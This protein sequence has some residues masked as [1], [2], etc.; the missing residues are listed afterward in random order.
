MSKPRVNRPRVNRIADS[1]LVTE[2]YLPWI[3]GIN[4]MQD[5]AMIADGLVT[6]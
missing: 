2:K 1:F 5:A 3:R 4:A 6:A